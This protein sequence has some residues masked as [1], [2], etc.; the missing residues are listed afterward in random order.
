MWYISPSI[1]Q[2]HVQYQLRF[3]ASDDVHTCQYHLKFWLSAVA[4]MT[5]LPNM[6]GMTLSVIR[7]RSAKARA[8]S[9]KRA[10]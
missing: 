8:F 4:L 5:G 3:E 2:R 9:E 10:T 7:T 1:M 6:R